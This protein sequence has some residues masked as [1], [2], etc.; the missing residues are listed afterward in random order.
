MTNAV[1]A[2]EGLAREVLRDLAR[3]GQWAGATVSLNNQM[4]N[5]DTTMYLL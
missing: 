3:T 4:H 5:M 2:I 1:A